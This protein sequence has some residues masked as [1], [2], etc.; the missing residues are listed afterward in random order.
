MRKQMVRFLGVMLA[1][2]LCA[3][4]A[5]PAQAA[6]SG[7]LSM[8]ARIDGEDILMACDAVVG[9]YEG[10]VVVFAD[11]QLYD[12]DE[13]TY[14]VLCGG[15][16]YEMVW[17][18]GM[19][20]KCHMF[21]AD[22]PTSNPGVL[23]IRGAVQGEPVVL[24]YD[25]QIADGEY[26]TRQVS[27]TVEDYS[28][29]EYTYQLEVSF[30][31][32][33]GQV[34][35]G[36]GLMSALLSED[37]ELLAVLT[38]TGEFH[39]RVIST[40]FYGS[41][42]TP[43]TGSSGS[44]GSSGSGGSSGSSGGSGSSGS[45]SSSDSKNG[46]QWPSYAISG[47]I[48]A[49]VGAFIRSRKKKKEAKAQSV[50]PVSTGGYTPYEPSVVRGAGGAASGMGVPDVPNV[51]N[52]PNVPDVPDAPP[53]Q[54]VEAIPPTMPKPQEPSVGA[55]ALYGI[56]GTMSGYRFPLGHGEVTFGRDMTSTICYGPNVPG[57]SRNHCK[58][59]WYNG[60]P[61]LMDVGSSYGTF[62]V[63]YGQIT[64]N[65]PVQLKPGD[66]FYLGEAINTFE[67]RQE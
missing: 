55:L 18:G 58:L 29:L 37:Q 38:A 10:Q 25:V 27:G 59:F 34:T 32:D 46:I 36:D 8:G 6:G 17:D 12:G 19:G 40:Q 61:T 14:V 7:V 5:V 53:V 63:G 22:I 26:E 24:H 21:Q 60:V 31:G 43:T 52:V 23:P 66:R 47:A 51:P 4:L 2:A 9:V 67:L 49:G 50:S 33:T 54:T 42:S 57:I 28:E 15:E 44:S 13:Y 3:V 64:P 35:Y 45:S 20:A 39:S 65:Q 11:E 30:S 1:V 16:V 41:G 48:A 56:G 62:V